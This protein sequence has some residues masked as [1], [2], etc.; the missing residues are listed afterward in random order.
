MARVRDSRYATLRTKLLWT[1]LF[2]VCFMIGRNIP[3]PLLHG[4]VTGTG[5]TNAQLLDIANIATGG[6][7]FFPSLFSLGLG[8][9][10]GAAILWRFLFLGQ[11][12]RDRKIPEET[13]NRARNVLMV[14]LAIIQSISLMTR[15]QIEPLPFGPFSGEVNAQIVVVVIFTV[16]AALVA[17][18]ANRN[19]AL[20]LG[21]VTMF[22]LYQLIITAMRN[23]ETLHV[24]ASPEYVHM[25]WFVII[26]CVCVVIIGV[27]AG[28]A[29]M[30][31]HV[32]KVS[33][34]SGFIGVSYL[35]I[36]LNPAGASPI[37]YALSLLAIPQF[38]VHAAGAVIPGA[39][40]GADR[41]LEVWGLSSP[42]GFTFYLV[43]LF[44][45]TIFFGLFTFKP[46]ETAERMRDGGEYFD[47][48]QPGEPTRRY[49]RR[50]VVLLSVLSGVF[51]VIFTGIPL[52]FIGTFPNLQYLLTAP[53]TLMI[54]LGLLWALHEEIADSRLGTKYVFSFRTRS[55]GATA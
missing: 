53:G 27:F 12:A 51:L 16:G 18:L 52:Y 50:R 19:E 2:F 23:F 21:G 49:I 24:A 13:V 42:I 30:R 31:L 46:K 33:I 34:D 38:I 6:N 9:W 4:T 44:V 7:F 47:H 48:V 41:F 55:G 15:Y 39:A 8:P 3:V 28:N 36:K 11:I 43:L 26:A 20:G 1:A 37:M 25:L 5:T 29:E 54:L 32:N 45:L 10:M 17:W 14:I 35:P 40:H 22:I